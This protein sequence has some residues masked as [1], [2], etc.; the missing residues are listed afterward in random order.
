MGVLCLDESKSVDWEGFFMMRVSACRAV[1]VLFL[2]VTC[3]VGC[4]SNNDVAPEPSFTASPVSGGSPLCVQFTDASKPGGSPIQAWYWEFGDG[5]SS[6]LPN[7]SHI[8]Y[9]ARAYSVS[10][11]V[12]SVFG[13]R[14]VTL[15]RYVSVTE[16]GTVALVGLGGDTIEAAEG[17]TLH[18]P[19]A[20][21]TK[22]VVF[23]IG[24][25]N[26][27]LHVDTAAGERIVSTPISIDHNQPEA[28]SLH[29][30]TPITMRFA[31]ASSSVS[32][33]NRTG[34]LLHV[35]ARQENG[36]TVPILGDVEG[37]AVRVCVT[38]LPRNAIYAVVF[39]PEAQEERLTVEPAS[40]KA[41][42]SYA[43]PSSMWRL[44]YTPGILQAATALRAGTLANPLLY[45]NRNF[46]ELTLAAT[47]ED[48][49]A[50][51][52]R[53]HALYR[54]SGFIS[55][56]LCTGTGN[57]LSLILY[58]FNEHPQSEFA[59]LA[60]VA[61]AVSPY[62]DIVIDPVQ[63]IEVCKKN[64][65]A[66]EDELLP[67]LAERNQEI[68]FRNALAQQLFH[69]VFRGYDFPPF[70]QRSTSD[71][72]L[73][74]R[75]RLV[76]F[77][78]GYEDG[79]ATFLGQVVANVRRSQYFIPRSMGFNEY[80]M[81]DEPLFAPFS[82]ST[83]A[84]SFASQDFLFYLLR[85]LSATP[86][87]PDAGVEPMLR[88][89]ADSYDG[90]LELIRTNEQA[91]V[92]QTPAPP[93]P[94]DAL[95]AANHGFELA[96]ERYLT[97]AFE[98]AF[99]LEPSMH[100]WDLYWDYAR[101]RAYENPSADSASDVL[102]RTWT[103]F[104]RP[105]DSVDLDGLTREPYQL[106]ADRFSTDAVIDVVIS[107]ANVPQ[108]ISFESEPLLKD[109]PPLSTRA[110][111]LTAQGVYGELELTINGFTW[112]PDI[113]GNSMKVLSCEE[114]KKG[115]EISTEHAVVS[116]QDF[117][118][119]TGAQRIVLLL[120]NVTLDH[121]YSVTMTAEVHTGQS[122]ATG[123]LG[124]QVTDATTTET[125]VDV[126]VEV[127]KQGAL[128]ALASTKTN[129]QGIFLFGSLPA[130][131]VELTLSKAGYQ[132]Q[133]VN[134]KVIPGTLTPIMISMQR[135]S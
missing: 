4:P 106:N 71:L 99:P 78:Q 56:R 97:P 125:I 104:L 129:S 120:C 135:G 6:T 108:E 109:I 5:A 28:L 3:L 23:R 18:V 2:T 45:N 43:W 11:S 90:V 66:V 61:F 44:S 81:L 65:E 20:A 64:A 105:M 131:D 116:Y 117:N 54:D 119:M 37:D 15:E 12:T 49:R 94:R 130:G 7:P 80:A 101:G 98:S 127:R 9:A 110:L 82:M 134:S 68:D 50:S 76:P 133:K 16:P 29:P 47:L 113:H 102:P 1:L 95:F 114:G 88:F 22:P 13:T 122:E 55:P 39:R 36:N 126:Q 123:S 92:N 128:D 111:V 51:V 34:A 87:T 40:V 52:K 31:F 100:L 42:T 79:I 91:L 25:T 118:G 38:G 62:G 93:M 89:L 41:P 19:P 73:A 14:R 59:R 60:D 84:Y 112:A 67:P 46:S 24:T 72:D 35:L 85:R 77:G 8:Y 26:V 57:E 63:L 32:A 30:N 48:I 69:E 86:S 83:P 17:V 124:G 33:N 132:T 70:V 53:I 115:V 103:S 21:L 27:A 74:G 107:Q 75:P 121:S 10:L 58:G 96:F